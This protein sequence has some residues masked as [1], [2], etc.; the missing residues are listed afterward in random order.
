MKSQREPVLGH[1]RGWCSVLLQTIFQLPPAPLSR[2]G[3]PAQFRPFPAVSAHPGRH[4]PISQALLN[5]LKKKKIKTIA[6][7][8]WGPPAPRG[9]LSSRPPSGSRRLLQPRDVREELGALVQG[10]SGGTAGLGPSGDVH[11]DPS[12]TRLLRE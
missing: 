5:G 9:L 2:A 7:C 8:A 3:L 4:V 1:W 11:D 10:D 12:G 6:S